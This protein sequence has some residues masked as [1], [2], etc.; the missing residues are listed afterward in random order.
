MKKLVALFLAAITLLSVVGCNNSETYQPDVPEFSCIHPMWM[1]NEETLPT[2][3]T[4]NPSS[5][6]VRICK[7]IFDDLTKMYGIDK[8]LPELRLV[9]SKV[10]TNS[11]V[12][13][14][15]IYQDNVL[16]FLIDD[17]HDALVAHELC[18]YLSDAGNGRVGFFHHVSGN[19]YTGHYLTEGIT[20]HFSQKVC[21]FRLSDGLAIYSFETHI[22][23]MLSIIYGE[24]YLEKDFFAANV[25]NLRRDFN[26]A[27]QD[28]YGRLVQD[29]DVFDAFCGCI[30]AYTLN[31][32]YA[33]N[34][35]EPK[36]LSNFQLLAI[37][38]EEM[39]LIYAS[40]KGC[41]EEA[42][43]EFRKFS[44]TSYKDILIDFSELL[45]SVR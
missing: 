24:K 21:P 37:G 40:K 12:Y 32:L 42:Y 4:K 30:D 44:E 36:A 25:E 43:A 16:Y 39:L 29:C 8:P 17:S 41:F 27:L 22:A 23:K 26:T 14:P 19:N 35:L 5:E 45:Q 11:L 3:E 18:H 34:T 28:S 31:M 13:V 7:A 6:T 9:T 1:S 15:A 20:N 10:N 2:V 33:Y 38:I